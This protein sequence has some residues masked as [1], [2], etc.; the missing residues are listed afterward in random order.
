MEGRRVS[1]PIDELVALSRTLGE[2]HRDLVVL[3]EGNTSVQVDEGRMVVKT[4]GSRLGSASRDDF[5]EVET[6][7]LLELIDSA[8]TDD[9]LVDAAMRAAR[10]G[11]E[12]PRPSMEAL[13]HAVCLRQPGVDVVAHTHP[14]AVNAILCSDQ[15]ERLVDGA[16]FPDQVVVMGRHAVLVPYADPGLA[17]AR[18]VNAELER[19][20]AEHGRPPKVV[21]LANHGIFVLAGST[22][23]AL[24]VTE[25]TVK[26]ARVLSGVLAVG[27][28]RYLTE[29]QAD[30]IDTRP[31][32]ALRRRRL[33][34]GSPC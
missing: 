30:R 24:A 21:Y 6:K 11:Q 16:L 9:S 29:A 14:V 1:D 22:A 25:M 13:V 23:E 15:A 33:A 18:A 7:P 31:D 3:A 17:L 5:V 4:S 26:T 34:E 12:R 20:V 10:G 32:E 28:P 8:E 19:F 2:P 27:R